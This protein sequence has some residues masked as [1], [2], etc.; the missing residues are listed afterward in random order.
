M[1][2]RQLPRT[3]RITRALAPEPAVVDWGVTEHLLAAVFDALNVA[4]WQRVAASTKHPPRAPRPLPRPGD[5]RSAGRI[6]RTTRSPAEVKAWLAS[7][8]PA[9]APPLAPPHAPVTDPEAA[10]G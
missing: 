2:V 7:F 3:A 8:N 4:N 10:H 9:P 6:G 1:L 5:K